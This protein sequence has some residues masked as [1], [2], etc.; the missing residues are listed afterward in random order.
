[1][2]GLE[3]R[4]GERIALRSVD[5]VLERGE[6]LGLVGP[7]GSGKTTLLKVLAGLLRPSAGSASVLGLDPF[8]ERA[9]LMQRARFAFAPAPLFDELSASENLRGVASL[10]GYYCGPNELEVTLETVGLSGRGADR[11]SSFSMGMKQRLALAMALLPRP[12]L[13]VLDEPTDGLDPLAVLELRAVLQRLRDEHGVTILLSSH[14]MVE[15]EELVDRVLVLMEGQVE[16]LGTPS[17]L[18]GDKARL[19]ITVGDGEAFS[20]ADCL[21]RAGH[22]PLE[23]NEER[24]ALRP[25]SLTLEQALELA[26]SD[27]IALRTFHVERPSMESA[28]LE[29]QRQSTERPDGQAC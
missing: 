8:K 11:V 28:L 17:Q 4:F 6:I 29:R 27:G 5:C 9:V 12:E 20:F 19:L 23:V 22:V 21:R 25:D 16:F 3:Y 7:N 1:M 2:N 18:L 14:L 26:R 10:G 13:L 24:I 15:V